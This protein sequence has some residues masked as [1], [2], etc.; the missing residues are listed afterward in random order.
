MNTCVPLSSP[1]GRANQPRFLPPTRRARI[2][3]SRLLPTWAFERRL[4]RCVSVSCPVS[5]CMSHNW[6]RSVYLSFCR[7]LR[8]EMEVIS[9]RARSRGLCVSIAEGSSGGGY[10]RVFCSLLDGRGVVF[11]FCLYT[12]CCHD[13]FSC[14]LVTSEFGF[15]STIPRSVAASGEPSYLRG[16]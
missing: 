7:V 11:S 1:S 15:K 2:L 13:I 14:S 12:Q 9:P 10:V 6:A 4:R 5:F 8:L 3:R 16:S